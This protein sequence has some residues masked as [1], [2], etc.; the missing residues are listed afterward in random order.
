MTAAADVVNLARARRA[1][2]LGER[3]DKVK[4]VDVIAHLF[5]LVSENAIRPAGHSADHE[6]RKKPVQ[7]GPGVSRTREA[8]AAKRNG[9][10]SKITSV[11]LDENVSRDFRSAK[12]RMLRVI[13]AH[14]FGNSRLVLVPLFDLPALLKF[15]QLEPLLRL[16]LSFVHRSKNNLLSR[17]QFSHHLH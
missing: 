7:L 17:T 10:H 4:T 13:D 16:P 12:E 3:F 1:N 14:R 11:F 9:W 8:A 2:E 6:I 5:A 15:A